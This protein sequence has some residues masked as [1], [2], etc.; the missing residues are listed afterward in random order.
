MTYNAPVRLALRGDRRVAERYIR[1]GRTLLFK[2]MRVATASGATQGRQTFHVDNVTIDVLFAGTQAAIVITAPEADGGEVKVKEQFVTWPR[3]AALLPGIDALHPQLMHAIKDDEWV[4][5][6]YD[7]DIAGYGDFTGV[8]GVYRR[9]RG[10]EVFPDGVRHA[11]NL[12]WRSKD[13]LRVSWYGP[14]SRYW[15]DPFVQPTAQYGKHVFMLGQVLLD[16]DQYIIDSSPDAPFPQLHVLGAALDGLTHL[17]VL[18]ATLPMF[19]DVTGEIV[20]QATVKAYMPVTSEATSEPV[21]VA[22]ARY[23]IAADAEDP[24]R[25]AVVPGSRVIIAERVI[26]NALA[27]WFFNE[28]AT[29]AV[30]ALP[31]ADPF[32]VATDGAVV[33]P[34]GDAGVIATVSANGDFTFENVTLPPGGNAPIAVDFRGNTRVEMRIQRTIAPDGSDTLH[35]VTPERSYL[36]RR[37]VLHTAQQQTVDVNYLRWADLRSDAVCMQEDQ[38]AVNFAVSGSTTLVNRTTLYCA[39]EAVSDNYPNDPTFVSGISRTIAVPTRGVLQLLAGLAVHPQFFLYQIRARTLLFPLTTTE[40]RAQ[41]ALMG[42]AYLNRRP[43]DYFGGFGFFNAAQPRPIST[44]AGM[45][46]FDTAL[47]ATVDFD[48]KYSSAG[49]AAYEGVAMFS[50]PALRSPYGA[51]TNLVVSPAAPT[52]L[53]QLTGVDGPKARYHPIWL[54]GAL[55]RQEV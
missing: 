22:L 50:G 39:G 51:S 17:L 46:E 11:G 36:L 43:E 29:H 8:K 48:G 24:T 27:P 49:G 21:A 35:V 19:P 23:A 52:T 3:T 15:F 54:L 14:S 12:D 38:I 7:R 25:F 1:T 18:S 4:T 20:P 53:P 33:R 13:G 40:L 6:F 37:D 34:P 9:D 31:P 30:S 5:L 45:T 47:D 28:A 2:A 26:D 10:E 16:V 55:P 44:V 41:G 42:F 32:Y